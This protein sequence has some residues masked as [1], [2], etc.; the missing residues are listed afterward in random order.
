M[1]LAPNLLGTKSE[2]VEFSWTADD[3][4][5]YAL[6]VGTGQDDPTT[7]LAYTTENTSGTALAVLPTYANIIT[8]GARIT[9]GDYDGANLVHAEQSFSLP[10]PLPVSGTAIVTA[11]VTEVLDKGRAALV[12]T[13]AT[14]VDSTTGAL[15]ATTAATV[16]ISGEGGFGGPRGESTPSPVP[17]T[18]PH[19]TA[20]DRD[21]PH[22]TRA[23]AALPPHRRP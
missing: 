3:V 21:R 13:E 15:L 6:A 5:L 8:R 10:A 1:T 4:M 11:T 19:R 12:R 22:Q 16:F 17:D 20:R 7:G 2:P 23:G 18:A 14:A 9:L